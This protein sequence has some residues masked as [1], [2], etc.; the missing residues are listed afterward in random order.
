LTYKKQVEFKQ[1][2][3][4]LLDDDIAVYDN[5]KIKNYKTFTFKENGVNELLYKTA[6]RS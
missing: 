2:L 4:K 6:T 1:H 5:K 3:D